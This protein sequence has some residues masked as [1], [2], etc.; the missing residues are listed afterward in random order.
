MSTPSVDVIETER[1]KS[2]SPNILVGLPDAGLVG[3]IAATYLVDSLHMREVGHIDSARFQPLIIVRE[4]EVRNPVRIYEKDD[5]VVVISDIPILPVMGVHFSRSLIGWAKKLDPKLVINITGLPVQNRLQLEKPEVLCLA[6]S[7]EVTELLRAAKLALF[8]DGV[9]FGTY[10]AVIKECVSQEIP[11]LT[12]LAQSHLNFPDPVASIEALTI[13]NNIFKVKVDL[14]QLR[15]EAEMIRIKT[16]E[17]M[18]QT[19]SA[20]RESRIEG[21]P[22]IYR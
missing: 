2:R 10:A 5:L 20:L 17:L 18:K 7:K 16:R 1:I 14:E 3:T 12:L 22:S 9:L 8:S 6:T 13:V 15:K 11:C 4:N 19:E 21:G